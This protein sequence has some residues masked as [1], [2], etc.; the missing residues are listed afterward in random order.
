MSKYLRNNVKLL[1]IAGIMASVLV[2]S[3]VLSSLALAEGTE[4]AEASATTEATASTESSAATTEATATTETT[5]PAAST[6][7]DSDAEA[8]GS[9]MGADGIMREIH[10]SVSTDGGTYNGKDYIPPTISGDFKSVSFS[11]NVQREGYTLVGFSTGYFS[12]DEINNATPDM[13]KPYTIDESG[14]VHMNFD[15][16]VAWSVTDD[17]DTNT[18][19]FRYHLT[20]LWA[21]NPEPEPEPQPQPEPEPEPAPV[22]PASDAT[23]TPT[24]RREKS[25]LPNTGDASSVAG[26]FAAAGTI[27][28]ALGL[29]KK[30]QQ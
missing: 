14:N 18:I 5:A 29:R 1:A 7:D 17:I 9:Y 20:T 24:P 10:I 2:F 28:V 15:D 11:S 6:D 3:P 26:V 21:P 12:Q 25:V 4:V 19:T 27:L 23:Q 8:V 13:S 30:I 16:I 22:V